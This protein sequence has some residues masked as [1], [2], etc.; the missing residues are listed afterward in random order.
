[1]KF[2]GKPLPLRAS[3]FRISLA[4]FVFGATLSPA[5]Q[6]LWNPPETNTSYTAEGG[7]GEW[8]STIANWWNGTQNVAWPGSNTRSVG[9]EGQGELITPGG[10]AERRSTD[11]TFRNLTGP[12]R[13]PG[14]IRFTS[15]TVEASGLDHP[16]T[17]SNLRTQGDTT[18]TLTHNGTGLL[19][20]NAL[21]RNT[22]LPSLRYLGSGPVHMRANPG[23]TGPFGS[24]LLDGSGR[25]EFSGTSLSNFRNAVVL[26]SGEFYV[27]NPAAEVD[28]NAF[29]WNGGTLIFELSNSVGQSNRLFIQGAFSTGSADE[30]VFDFQNTGTNRT[31]T[32]ILYDPA[33]AD[34]DLNKF[35][36]INVAEGGYFSLG[37]TVRDDKPYGTVL[38]TVTVPHDPGPEPDPEPEP[39]PEPFWPTEPANVALNRPATAKNLWT[40]NPDFAPAYT[41]ERAV[42]GDDSSP[43]SRWI[44]SGIPNWI[45]VDLGYTYAIEG[46]RIRTGA[47]SGPFPF[48]DFAL[49]YWDGSAWVD[50]HAVTGNS[51]QVHEASFAP[52]VAGNRVRLEIT[53]ASDN[54]ARLYELEVT[55]VAHALHH[56]ETTPSARGTTLSPGAPIEVV[57]NGNIAA[58]DLSGIMVRDLDLSANLAGVSASVAG[59]TL[60]I[61]H[62]G[63]T[64]EHRFAVTIPAGAV[65]AAGDPSTLNGTLYWEF[66]VAPE[67][68]Q[69]VEHTTDSQSV[70]ADLRYTF[71]RDITLVDVGL[72]SI[73]NASDF[74]PVGGISATVSNGRRLDISHDAFTPGGRYVVIIEPGAIE[75]VI[76]G[77]PNTTIRRTFFAQRYILFSGDF[78]GSL[79]GFNTAA[80]LGFLPSHQSWQ[81]GFDEPGPGRDF[82]YIANTSRAD[83]L[84]FL[85]SPMVPLPPGETYLLTARTSLNATLSVGLTTTANREDIDF[86][87]TLNS[88]ETGPNG[89]MVE[90]QTEE[91]DDYFLIFYQTGGNAYQSMQL[92]QIT[93]SR[94]GLPAIQ[95]ESPADE[96]SFLETD[97]IQLQAFAFAYGAEVASVRFYDNEA[98]LGVGSEVE[99]GFFVFNWGPRT[100]GIRTVTAE[101]TDT[102]GNIATDTIEIT[103]TF[104]DG[105]LPPFVEWNFNGSRQNWFLHNV[106]WNQNRLN[107]GINWRD[108]DPWAASPVVFLRAGETY[109]LEFK[110]RIASTGDST[111]H[112]RAHAF[113]EPGFPTLE[114]RAGEM[115]FSIGPYPEPGGREFQVIRREFSVAEDGAYHIHFYPH[116]SAGH[117]RLA[118][119]FDDVRVIGNL[120]A[121]PVVSMARPERTVTTFE[122]T[123]ILLEANATDPDGFIERVEFR[124]PDG[125]LVAPDAIVTSP[126]WQY[127]WNDLE[128]GV[129]DVAAFAEDD[130]GG[131]A[132][133]ATRRVTVV[134]NTI[135]L[136]TFLGS[137]ATD[138]AFTAAVYQSD[139]TL[140][141]SG[142]MDPALMPGN[143]TITYLNGAQPGDR[144][145][146]ARL[147]E[148][149]SQVLSVTVVGP[150]VWDMALDGYDN[151]YVA[152]AGAGVVILNPSATS[153]LWSA[154]YPKLVHR[155][156][157]APGGAFAI[158]TST[159]TNYMDERIGNVTFHIYD[160][161][162]TETAATGGPAFTRDLAIDEVSETVVLIGWKND[163]AMDSPPPD[164]ETN[165]VDIPI[166]IGVNF[167]GTLRWRG[168]DWVRYSQDPTRHLNLP[169]N[170]MADTRGHRVTIGP[171]GHIYAAFE[172]DG[173]NHPLRWSPLDI[174][175]R[176]EGR[177]VGGDDFHRTFN[178]GTNPKVFVG[179]YRVDTG[180]LLRGQYLVNRFASGNESVINIR[181]GQILVDSSLRVHLVDRSSAGLPLSH[182]PLSGGNYTGGAYYLVLS[183]DFRSRELLT[184]LNQD[185]GI[186]QGIAISSTGKTTIV[187]TTSSPFIH[188]IN[189]WQSTLNTGRDALL[190]VG[191]FEGYFQFQTGEHPRLFFNADELAE[192]RSRLDREPFISMYQALIDN[193]DQGDFY[194][195][196][197]ENNPS[198]L[199]LRARGHAFAYALSADEAHAIAAR[200]NIESAFDLIGS[201][202]AATNV[203]GLSLYSRAAD[204]AIAY[205]LCANSPYWDPGFNYE[206]SRRLVEVADVIVANGGQQQP[207]NVGSNWHAHRGAGAGLAYLATDHSFE[208]DRLDASWNRVN[209]YLA[210]N[211][212]NRP[213][214]GWNPE[215]FGYTAYPF[216]LSVGPYAIA[217]ARAEPARDLTVHPSL[218]A[219]ARSG[220]ITATSAFNVFGTGGIKTDWSNDNAHIG[221]EG[222]FGQAFRISAPEDR[223]ALRHAYDRLLGALAPHGGNWDSTRHGSF[224][225]ILYYPEDLTPQDPMENWNWHQVSDDTDGLGKFTFRNGYVDVNDILVQFKTRNY[226]LDQTNWGPDGLGIRALGLGESLIVGGGRNNPGSKSGQATVY[227]TN[228][229]N[230]DSFVSNQNTGSVVGTPLIKPDGGGHAIG[231][232]EVSNVTTNNHKR[233]VVT[234]FATAQ[235]GAEAVIVV[236]DTSDDG[237]WWQLP[238]FLDNEIVVNGSEFTITGVNGATLRGTIL[239]PGGT[240]TISIGTRERGAAYA[241]RNGGTLAEVDPDTNP[242]IAENRHLMIQSGGDGDFLVVMTL[243]PEGQSHP[244]VSRL[245]GGV[246]DAVIQVGTRTYTLQSEDV[247]YDGAP[248]VA[249]DVTVTFVSGG[250]G[251]ITAG[252]SIQTLAYGESPVPP[253]VT[254]NEGFVFLGWDRAVGPVVRDMTITAVYA[255]SDQVEPAGFAAWIA[256]F[257]ALPENERGILASPAGDGWINLHKYAFGMDPLANSQAG[258]P[259]LSVEDDWLVL[260]YRVNDAATDVTVVP[261]YSETLT[262]G[263]WQAVPPANILNLGPDGLG[264]T[265]Y[266]AT[267]PI[268]SGPLFLAVE[269]TIEE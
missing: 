134:P 258:A 41:A 7:D 171:D 61:T 40:H 54:T 100:P 203:F 114:Q 42:D 211:A 3:R 248:Y 215:G 83:D 260:T 102:N 155:I 106:T 79:D 180:E 25:F 189:A 206:V 138:E 249:P 233:W 109:I 28:I 168:Y 150:V 57:F 201:A 268:G 96:S 210:L 18:R 191:D 156:D 118:V 264:N 175:E 244:T 188:P 15:I 136:N 251:T 78:D 5:Q 255:T 20:F 137:T 262:P 266:E 39:E 232:M 132:L 88:A 169:T 259:T 252:D 129:Y 68:P 236:A 141:I 123:R 75:S 58:V 222:L 121:A 62:G 240:P 29:T 38:Y 199:M 226:A 149:A 231:H 93:L 105:T 51:D 152:A 130:Q 164:T 187:G 265:V 64:R 122:G 72:I 98:L 178:T 43:S 161:T 56:I 73:L 126:P 108:N 165:P 84:D 174:M 67:A 90:F 227:R 97:P 216:G 245:S 221:G 26:N 2:F 256:G 14:E 135:D 163:V 52:V 204:L 146:V 34:F 142:I 32:L 112:M 246:A 115:E 223:P 113:A 59:D 261:V 111:F 4:L 172:F 120:N 220:F 198:S 104:D 242:L 12:Y 22:G 143:P 177:V 49:Q 60:T 86:I 23:G 197:D 53:A 207:N 36:A 16:I 80:T 186:Y 179:R 110:A 176:V 125:S 158:I 128:E 8:S 46:F 151:I 190:T 139:D 19:E 212:G 225:S 1:M 217:Q 10:S 230:P 153:V 37:T 103:V 173:G 154:T 74:S 124:L 254:A 101:I 50:I 76:D 17:L 157:A 119:Q 116:T 45:E 140:V 66:N 35:T 27:S 95:I 194:R 144:G 237:L 162:W 238:T 224:W 183:P 99:E 181:Y 71:D 247:L 170:N 228:P 91:D 148:D 33:E 48:H 205:D 209:Q 81:L 184:R 82:S 202:W 160:H 193:L 70:T 89:R 213:T 269:V 6:L 219:K 77:A 47:P 267:L 185:G 9:F 182:D 243:Q 257:P 235:T 85:L 250:N 167:D 145:I 44:G 107:I 13:I 117:P 147:T 192:I 253:V 63:L 234:D 195:P 239:H 196:V 241:L 24:L 65:S 131:F 11:I 214:R 229:D 94:R 127:W 159:Q 31:Y 87:A 21:V 55:G 200:E 69:V 208:R 30:Y 92:D 263:S 166:L 133:S 218:R